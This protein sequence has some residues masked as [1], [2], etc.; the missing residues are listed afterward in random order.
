MVVDIKTPPL[1]GWISDKY[2]LVG[3]TRRPGNYV[4]TRFRDVPP[5][6]RVQ[7]D[8]Q[9]RIH[10]Q[11]AA[12]RGT[13]DGDVAAVESPEGAISVKVMVTD[14]I[15]P[16]FVI[17]DFGWGNSWDG[18]PNVNIL[19]SDQPRCPISGATPNRRFRCEVAKT[20]GA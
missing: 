6:H 3:T 5:L 20:Q 17:V 9:L 11:D 8:P 7:P 13:S 16:G 1:S 15:R 19:T 2:P 14:E 10:P 18:G 4:H 12:L